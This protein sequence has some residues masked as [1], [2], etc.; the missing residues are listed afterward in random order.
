MMHCMGRDRFSFGWRQCLGCLRVLAGLLQGRG[1]RGVE[2]GLP[3]TKQRLRAVRQWVSRPPLQPK[4]R[5]G[6]GRQTQSARCN[7]LHTQSAYCLTRVT[8]S[9][10]WRHSVELPA[11]QSH[12][13]A[14]GVLTCV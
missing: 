12:A 7:C 3:R 2:Q 9:T 11:K 13:L 1:W 8:F 6:R 4:L 10:Q 14:E 5:R